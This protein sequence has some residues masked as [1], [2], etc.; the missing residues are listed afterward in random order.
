MKALHTMKRLKPMDTKSSLKADHTTGRGQATALLIQ[1]IAFWA[2]VWLLRNQA[3]SIVAWNAL[4]GC[5]A[6]A[7]LALHHRRFAHF[8]MQPGS[9]LL[10]ALNVVLLAALFWGANTALDLINGPHR[11]KVDWAAQLGGLEL[12]FVLFPGVWSIAM[13]GCA[14][15]LQAKLTK[16]PASPQPQTTRPSAT[17]PHPLSNAQGKVSETAIPSSH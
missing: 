4:Y 7:A 11:P 2:G 14:R 8:Q 13:T 12:W 10:F 5:C 9:W 15:S 6:L 16:R 17:T 1:A 3:V